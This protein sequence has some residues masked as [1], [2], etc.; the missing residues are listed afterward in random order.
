MNRSRR[1]IVKDL[2]RTTGENVSIPI[3]PQVLQILLKSEK[4]GCRI[5]EEVG[6]PLGEK[7]REKPAMTV[8]LE[9]DAIA[10]FSI[11]SLLFLGCLS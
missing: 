10:E 6:R 7:Y 4:G 11:P 3:L 9:R 5:T 8:K 2:H 1:S